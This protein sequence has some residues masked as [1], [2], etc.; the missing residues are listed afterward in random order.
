M[1][2]WLPSP[3]QGTI[4]LMLLVLN[5]LFWCFFLFLLVILKV[6][7]PVQSFRR[8]V[9]LGLTWIAQSWA[10][11]NSLAVKHL[12]DVH[13]DVRLPEGID[14]NGQY[15]ACANHRS[16]NDIVA[17]MFAFG[18]R[19]PFF[20][21]FLKQ[22]L[23]WVPILGVA[24]W[25]LDYPF[26]KRYSRADIERNPALKGKDMETTRKACEKFIDQP[27]MVLNF[28]EGTRFTPAKH[29]AQQSPFQHL[30]KPKSGGLAFA[31]A[32][33]GERVNSL[34]NITIAYPSGTGGLW[35]LLSGQVKEVVVHAETITIPHEFYDGDYE[36]DPEFRKRYQAWV[37]GLWTQKDQQIGQILATYE[38]AK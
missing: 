31:T 3:V 24:W 26:M 37:S 5:T 23:I 6:V 25:A 38:A 28:L 16:W 1:L 4:L 27:V 18:R 11:G 7:V 34:V 21:F 9:S 33:F 19:A 10:A 17:L 30:L 32:A 13:W 8:W 35:S 12:L 15:L 22:E 2:S 14:P 20:K 29:A 36:N